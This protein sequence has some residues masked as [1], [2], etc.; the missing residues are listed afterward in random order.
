MEQFLSLKCTQLVQLFSSLANK[1]KSQDESVSVAA[2]KGTTTV[3]LRMV[4]MLNECEVTLCDNEDVLIRSNE[5]ALASF[6]QPEDT[7]QSIPELFLPEE[8]PI[9]PVREFPRL[10]LRSN[11]KVYFQTV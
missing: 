9:P 7:E 4:T 6:C 1:I 11:K 10:A 2:V 3:T 8:D 5:I